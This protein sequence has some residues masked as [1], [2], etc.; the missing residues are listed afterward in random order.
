MLT[1]LQ[2]FNR[3]ELCKSSWSV[4]I[5]TELLFTFFF[6]IIKYKICE[7]A[8]MP[9]EMKWSAHFADR[10]TY[11]VFAPFI[12][13]FI[14]FMPFVFFFY[15]WAK[16][17][18]CMPNIQKTNALKCVCDTF[19]WLLDCTARFIEFTIGIASN[20]LLNALPMLFITAWNPYSA[21]WRT[22]LCSQFQI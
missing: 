2:W 1:R 21:I 9:M 11:T 10:Y 3:S 17:V 14:I 20:V 13:F 12:I 15:I 22:H 8:L 6:I 4:C 19:F 16:N 7:N 18:K 5:Y